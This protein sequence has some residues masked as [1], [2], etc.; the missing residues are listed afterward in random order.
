MFT[1]DN[2]KHEKKVLQELGFVRV[3]QKV[4]DHFG[5]TNF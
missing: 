2:T 5:K 4:W 3:F 1:I